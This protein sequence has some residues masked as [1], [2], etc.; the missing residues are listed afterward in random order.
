MKPATGFFIV[1]IIAFIFVFIVLAFGGYDPTKAF[2][3]DRL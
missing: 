3:M 1:L 2:W